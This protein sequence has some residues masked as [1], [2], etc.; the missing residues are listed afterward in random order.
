M[1]QSYLTVPHGGW[2]DKRLVGRK[3]LTRLRCGS[4]DLRIDTGR[5]DGLTADERLCLVCGEGDV[6]TEQ[7]FLLECNYYQDDRTTLWESL[8]RLV[9]EA[10]R[11]NADGATVTP[12]RVVD[13][14][15][16]DQLTLIVGGYHQRINGDTLRHRVMSAILIAIG[17][18]YQK[19]R[20][21]M[22]VYNDVTEA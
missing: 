15:R 8:E 11:T 14:T 12:F 19:R 2:S 7:H 9:N 13:L 6:E 10:D 17:E 20:Q 3:V 21:W 4:N 5:W 18:W 1:L 22:N 16:H